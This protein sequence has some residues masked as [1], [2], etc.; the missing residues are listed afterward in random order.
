M[1]EGRVRHE[2]NLLDTEPHFTGMR[3]FSNR[4]RMIPC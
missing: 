2:D 1:L 3:L 4:G